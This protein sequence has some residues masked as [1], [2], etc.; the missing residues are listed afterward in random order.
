M[1]LRVIANEHGGFRLY[2]GDEHVGWIEDRAIGFRGFES[3]DEAGRA[4]GAA[5]DAL[6]TWLAR[7][8]RTEPMPGRRRALRARRDGRLTRLTLGSVPVGRIIEPT[9]DAPVQDAHYGF[10][11][12]LPPG[13]GP[14]AAIGA[15]QVIDT[16]LARRAAVQGLERLPAGA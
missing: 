15:A 7:Q 9:G 11:L 1:S 3:A 2:R 6:R 8:H 10:E 4:A 12:L 16:A 14:V 5:Y 13:L